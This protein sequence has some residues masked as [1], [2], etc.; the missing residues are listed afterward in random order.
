MRSAIRTAATLGLLVPALGCAYFNT[1]YNARAKYREAQDLKRA[2]DPERLQISGTEER[3]YTEAFE[4][5]AKVVK[6]YPDSKW[7]DDALLLMGKSAFEKGDY[8]TALRKFDEVLTFYPRSKLVPETLLMKG[9]TLIETR[10]YDAG[11]A[12]LARASEIDDERI[13]GDVVYFRG[14]AEQDQGNPDEALAAFS[15]VVSRHRDSEW[16]AEAGIRAGELSREQGDLQTAVSL[17]EK[18]RA[19]ARE[20]KDRYRAGM[21][22][23]ETLMEL[24]E[25]KRAATTFEDVRKRTLDEEDRGKAVLMRGKARLAGGDLEGAMEVFREVLQTYERREAAAEAQLAIAS[26]HD[27]AGD[28]EEAL[29]QYELVKEQGTAFPAWQ[30][31]SA[32][33]SEIQRVLDLREAL[34]DPADPEHDR[35]RF[36][37]A[38]HLLERIGDVDGALAEYAALAEESPDSEWAA[39]ALFA[40]A[41][42]REHRLGEPAAAESILFRIA[43]YTRGSE[44]TTAARRRLGYPVWK[45]EVL[46]PPPVRFVRMGEE[47]EAQEVVVSRVDP[48]DVPLPPGASQVKVWVLVQVD[49]DGSARSA[50]VTKSG[51]AE[52]DEAAMEAARASR[53]LPP[54]EGGP[55]YSV[56]QYVFPPPRADSGAVAADEPSAAERDAMLDARDAAAETFTSPLVPDGADSLGAVAPADTIA[57]APADTTAPAPPDR[58]QPGLPGFRDRRMSGSG[59]D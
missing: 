6:F 42:V 54:S 26:L 30:E 43:N 20:P 8:S 27:E 40:Q 11:A 33:R 46:Q 35:N 59:N 21:L 22:K 2:A 52:F 36:L 7:V 18:V 25:T 29:V 44:V 34:A 10:E 3:L 17:F 16:F 39:R 13:R 49:D 31:A 51:G 19:R 48:R 50:S 55:E 57:P 32:R 38:E 9:R 23:G 12:V 24:G 4:K 37:L 28:F 1:L 5:A 53:Y 56:L 14:V 15:E 58:V 47:E 41:W 45:V